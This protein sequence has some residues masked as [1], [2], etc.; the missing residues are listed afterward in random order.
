VLQKPNNSSEPNPKLTEQFEKITESFSISFLDTVIQYCQLDEPIEVKQQLVHSL[1]SEAINLLCLEKWERDQA[2]AIGNKLFALNFIYPEILILTL[3]SFLSKLATELSSQ[4]LLII[5]PRLCRLSTEVIIG[6]VSSSK[7]K[8]LFEQEQ[9]RSQIEKAKFEAEN[10][11]LQVENRHNV[12][13]ENI[14]EIIIIIDV[15]GNVIYYHSGKRHPY[16]TS[17]NMEE[18]NIK[19]FVPKDLYDNFLN[20][21][22]MVLSTG[23]NQT[24]TTSFTFRNQMRV[25]EGRIAPYSEDKTITIVRDITEIVEYQNALKTSQENLQEMTRLMISI[26]ESER[27]QIALEL[28]DQ[29]LSQLGAVFLYVDEATI[30]QQFIDNYHK[31]VDQIRSTIY[32]LRPPM[33]NYGLFPALD[34]LHTYLN[35]HNQ[36]NAQIEL[37]VPSSEIRVDQKAELHL[38]RIIQEATNNACKHSLASRIQINGAINTNSILFSVEDNGIGMECCETIDL[39]K[40]L[41]NN[42]FGI[43]GMFERAALIDAALSITSKPQEGTKVTINWKPKPD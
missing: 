9:I 43:A 2:I 31:L 41:V 5:Y 30:P 33:L 26:Q 37:N 1:I 32:N 4:E 40:A 28:H 13:V 35:N 42:H 36:T 17:I 16:K 21:S 15:Q 14:P 34:D 29:V 24:L 25:F 7:E 20:L 3:E 6:F 22:K 8:I 19:N 11:R 18:I 27:H 38:F 12:I 10:A 23:E 39:T